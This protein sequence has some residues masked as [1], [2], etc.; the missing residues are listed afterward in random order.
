MKRIIL[1]L[2]STALI[3]LLG[4]P[5]AAATGKQASLS[6]VSAEELAIVTGGRCVSKCD[7]EEDEE[8]EED[9]AYVVG[10]EWLQ[11]KQVDYA[12]EQR[13]YSIVAERS[14]VYGTS[15]VNYSFS[16]NDNCRYQWTSGGVG[17]STGFNVSIGRSY[18]CGQ[19]VNVSGTLNPGYRVK[20]YRGEM[21]QVQKVTV[22][23]YA[24]YSDGS[25][26]RTGKS[27]TGRRVNTWYR[28]SDV[29]AR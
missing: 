15:R 3:A 13:S 7:D 10:Y 1:T 21:R 25:S 16:F 4:L 27:D 17:I 20:I 6:L 29:V 8:E 22:S 11:T 12:A 2:F 24:V 14:N 26:E 5:A 28:Y 9:D 19:T 18:Y 23:Q